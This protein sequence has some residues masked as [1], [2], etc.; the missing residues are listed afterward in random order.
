MRTCLVFI[1]IYACGAI[2]AGASEVADGQP[3]S[4]ALEQ[5]VRECRERCEPRCGHPAVCGGYVPR[6]VTACAECRGT[7]APPP[8][9]DGEQQPAPRGAQVSG[10]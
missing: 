5:L 2:W 10:A 4:A 9:E 3:A 1:V 6:L 8:G 7:E